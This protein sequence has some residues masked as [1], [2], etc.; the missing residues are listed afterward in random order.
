L[1]R[2]LAATGQITAMIDISDGLSR[3]LRQICNASNVSAI[4]ESSRVPVHADAGGMLERALHDGEDH[5]L[6]FTARDG[7]VHAG[8]TR[9][10]RT[11]ASDSS[12]PMVF[13]E[14]DARCV[15]L[16]ERGWTARW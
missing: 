1:S 10:G 8:C 12:G 7:F 14:Q 13:I 3:D 2:Q 16:P 11:I 4:V 5:E 9:I 6:L 15:E